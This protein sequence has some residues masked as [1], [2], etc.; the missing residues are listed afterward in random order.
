MELTVYWK[1]IERSRPISLR[2]VHGTL[3]NASHC[4][5]HLPYRSFGLWGFSSR[6]PISLGESALVEGQC[7]TTIH[8][9]RYLVF[10]AHNEYLSQYPVQFSFLH[11]DL[12][13]YLSG[14]ENILHILRILLPRGP[15][16]Q[17]FP[18]PLF[19]QWV[20]VLQR[21]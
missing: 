10:M 8:N 16:T 13:Y 21:S 7:S 1:M 19:S 17:V 2:S 4:S 11:V 14:T 6:S 3:H 18:F 15:S 5:N 20:A 12:R 9:S